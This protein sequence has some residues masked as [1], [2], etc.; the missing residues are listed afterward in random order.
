MYRP[1]IK[2]ISSQILENRNGSLTV[3]EA[4]AQ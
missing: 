3:F 1:Y 4:K 2:K